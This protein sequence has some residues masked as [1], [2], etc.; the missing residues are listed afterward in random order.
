MADPVFCDVDRTLRRSLYS[1]GKPSK[2]P[3]R[4]ISLACRCLLEGKISRG[5]F[6]EYTEIDRVDIDEYLVE[7]GFM[8]QNYEKIAAI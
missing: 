3:S 2:F 8:E 6:A 4:F 1:G 5:V 7:A